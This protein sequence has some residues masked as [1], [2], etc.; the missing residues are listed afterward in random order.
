MSPE[1]RA[2]QRIHR[3]EQERNRIQNL[4][5]PDRE[6]F[7]QAHVD[8]Q[9]NYRHNQQTLTADEEYIE[10][11]S[12]FDT[13]NKLPLEEHPYVKQQQLQF[14]KEIAKYEMRNCITCKERWPTEVRINLPLHNYECH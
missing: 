8:R 3:T 7:N 9:H 6:A 12:T 1:V 5:G 11:L 13:D 2:I 10:Y 4:E 14:W